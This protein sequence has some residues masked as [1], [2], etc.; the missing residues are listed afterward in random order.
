MELQL[1]GELGR[2]KARMAELDAE[3]MELKGRKHIIETSLKDLRE[4]SRQT[5][6]LV[7]DPRRRGISLQQLTD[8]FMKECGDI[9][10]EDPTEQ[11]LPCTLP[12]KLARLCNQRNQELSEDI[13]A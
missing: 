3:M 9:L 13:A 4:P 1:Q 5:I 10:F 6:V 12:S 7:E 2:I 8:F 11:M